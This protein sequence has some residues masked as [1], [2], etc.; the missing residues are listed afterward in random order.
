MLATQEAVFAPETEWKY[1]NLALAVAGELVA[2]ISGEPW[3]AYL[4]KH[5]L[6]P[7]GMKATRTLPEPNQADL[8]VGYA[9]KLPGQP[10]QREEFSDTKG[11]APAANMSSNVED[12]ARFLMLQFQAGGAGGRRVL[13]GATLREMQR[14]HWLR[15]DWKGGSGLGFQIRR[16]GD[17]T[18]VGHGGSL[19][20]YRTQIEFVPQDKVGV[21][22][23]TNSNEGEPLKYV[24]QAFK[25]AGPALVKAY[26]KPKPVSKP[27]PKWDKYVGAYTWRNE[28]AQVLVL[29]GQLCVITPSAENPW[30]T[31]TRLEPAGEHT[32]RMEGGSSP[33]ELLRFDI[34]AAGNVTR[35]HAGAF[36]RDRKR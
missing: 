3:A 6:Q 35:M 12:L 15:P 13:R 22:V 34:D 4:E 24:D 2:A 1:S 33:G 23:L 16:A 36:Y 26:G 18:R 30:E 17:Q 27:D 10:R 20:G 32:F 8:A 31:R 5:I 14:I 7:L 11:I 21:I 25:I 9:K 28:D 29:E 19:G